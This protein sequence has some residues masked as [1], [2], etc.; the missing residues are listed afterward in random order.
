MLRS[1]VTSLSALAKALG[2]FHT[3]SDPY[4]ESTG[5][6][7]SDVASKNIA[8]VEGGEMSP[9]RYVEWALQQLEAEQARALIC[10]D[11]AVAV[12]AVEI[13]EREIGTKKQAQ[14]VRRGKLN[15]RGVGCR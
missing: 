15:C 11:A 10:L 8:A 9:S 7:F 1:V 12:A 13:A 3:I 2:T 14:I 5:W 6:H 4:L